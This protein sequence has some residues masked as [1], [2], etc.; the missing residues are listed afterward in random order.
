MVWWIILVLKGSM[1]CLPISLNYQ[2]L[3]LISSPGNYDF[4]SPAAEMGVLGE[5][6][7]EVILTILNIEGRLLKRELQ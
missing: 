5:E 1:Y 7:K 4:C 6:K 2:S 3:F